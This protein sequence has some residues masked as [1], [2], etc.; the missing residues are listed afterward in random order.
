MVGRSRV[1]TKYHMK[2]KPRTTAGEKDQTHYNVC[3][4]QVPTHWTCCTF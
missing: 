1:N 3:M 4:Q 2:Q